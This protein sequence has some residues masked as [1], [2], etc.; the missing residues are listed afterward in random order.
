MIRSS[1]ARGATG[2]SS[3]QA[4]EESLRP[5]SDTSRQRHSGPDRNF[6]LVKQG[7]RKASR[8]LSDRFEAIHRAS[9]PWDDITNGSHE[10]ARIA[11]NVP[12][13]IDP[14]SGFLGELEEFVRGPS[15]MPH[16]PNDRNRD[17]NHRNCYNYKANLENRRHRLPRLT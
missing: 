17:G 11:R 16:L 13:L 2:E 5:E 10:L 7:V 3:S 8:A 1:V 9:Q 15:K 12:E 4:I 6:H 14:L